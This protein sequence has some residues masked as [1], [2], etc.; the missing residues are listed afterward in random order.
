MTADPQARR[1]RF[2]DLCAAALQAFARAGYEWPDLVEGFG[3][4]GGT[5]LPP[6]G[7]FR[8]LAVDVV[9]TTLKGQPEAELR[10]LMRSRLY[11]RHLDVDAHFDFMDENEENTDR[12]ELIGRAVWDC[13]R[14]RMEGQW[15]RDDARQSRLPFGRGR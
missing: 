12:A 6:E 1:L 13:L 10:R 2:A 8:D 15:D 9:G 3:D 4:G 5:G 11:R 14:C 7:T